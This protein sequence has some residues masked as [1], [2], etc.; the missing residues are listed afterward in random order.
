MRHILTLVATMALLVVHHARGDVLITLYRGTTPQNLPNVTS[1]DD[2]TITLDENVTLVWI[3]GQGSTDDLGAATLAGDARDDLKVLVRASSVFLDDPRTLILDPGLRHWAGFVSTSSLAKVRLVAALTGNLTGPVKAKQVFRL[4]VSGELIGDVTATV[5]DNWETS[6]P[7]QR[8][9]GVVRVGGS[10][11]EYAAIT[12]VAGGI[13]RVDVGPAEPSSAETPIQAPITAANGKIDS[14]YC[15]WSID[16]PITAKHGIDLIEAGAITGEITANYENEHAIGGTDDGR[17]VFILLHPDGLGE[18]DSAQ[19]LAPVH[20]NNFGFVDAV[21][22]ALVGTIR[23]FDVLEP[24]TFTGTFH[25]TMLVTNEINPE[26][27]VGVTIQEGPMWGYIL[28]GGYIKSVT[29]CG[30][31]ETTPEALEHGFGYPSCIE[32]LTEI[33]DVTVKGTI[34]DLPCHDEANIRAPIIGTVLC[35]R[36]AGRLD[37]TP[38][39]PALTLFPVEAPAQLVEMKVYDIVEECSGTQGSGDFDGTMWAHVSVGVDIWNDLNGVAQIETMPEPSN[40]WIGGRLAGGECIIDESL[41]AFPA[42]IVLRD[43]FPAQIIINGRNTMTPGNEDDY[44]AGSVEKGVIPEVQFVIA[45][46]QPQPDDSPWY[47]RPSADF[48]GG[49]S[50]LV[51]FSLHHT[52]CRPPSGETVCAVEE[53]RQWPDETTRQTIVLRHYGPPFDSLP[54]DSTIPYVIMTQSLFCDSGGCPPWVDSSAQFDVLVQPTENG[55]VKRREVCVSRVL[56]NG[57]PQPFEA[58]H[59]YQIDLREDDGATDLRSDET[60]VAMP[61][62]PNIIRYPYS[63]TLLCMD[64]NMNGS[65]DEPDVAEWVA[66]PVDFTADSAADLN[67]L[68][69]LVDAIA[70]AP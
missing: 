13:Y 2:V 1:G 7:E 51:P 39:H 47:D 49:A 45:P 11:R 8:S 15:A 38:S 55:E 40:L 41:V 35:G 56:L 22:P 3:R 33:G 32:S 23:A 25:G 68:A 14:V 63:L 20:A 69:A 30:D 59:N 4:Q 21:T 6:G 53:V 54:N 24:M 16:A 57:Q 17:I 27:G 50:G 34:G 10:V 29:V 5:E 70:T 44:W 60:A 9:I 62:T 66:A 12:A 36:F 43:Q 48:G 31:I 61:D 18:P 64:L 65:I 52:D 58:Y 19:I 46:T 67:D 26:S 42:R 37:G 28:A